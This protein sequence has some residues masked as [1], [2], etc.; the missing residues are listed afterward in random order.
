MKMISVLDDKQRAQKCADFPTSAGRDDP[1]ILLEIFC[2]NFPPKNDNFVLLNTRYGNGELFANVLC[3][4]QFISFVSV[5]QRC[6][7][8]SVPKFNTVFRV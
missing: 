5:A 3:F 1:S 6:R 7:M 2:V 4:I 8:S